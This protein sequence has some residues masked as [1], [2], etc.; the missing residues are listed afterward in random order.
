MPLS[1]VRTLLATPA[2][3]GLALNSRQ[4]RP[5]FEQR[6]NKKPDGLGSSLFRARILAASDVVLLG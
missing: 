5:K 6:E 4:A 1:L 3:G 2:D